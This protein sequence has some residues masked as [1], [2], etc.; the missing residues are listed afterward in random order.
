ME[1][2]THTSDYWKNGKPCYTCGEVQGNERAREMIDLVNRIIAREG[3]WRLTDHPDDPDLATYGGMRFATWAAASPVVGD[4]RD[5]VRRAQAHD[6]ALQDEIRLIFLRR[7]VEPVI[8]WFPAKPF[9]LD[10]E[11][12][13]AGGFAVALEVAADHGVTSGGRAAARVVQRAVGVTPDGIVGRRTCARI[14]EALQRQG[15]LGVAMRI[16]R[17]RCAAYAD[18][19]QRIPARIVFVEG[20]MRRAMSA[21]IDAMEHGEDA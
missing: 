2:C 6:P 9:R 7:F 1:D 16:T 13:A 12:A 11:R 3:G 17:E 14:D 21:A 10:A 20:W 5:F 18:I 8:E 15:D 19:A 4:L